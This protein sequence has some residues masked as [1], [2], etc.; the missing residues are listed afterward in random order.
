M[1]RRSSDGGTL[2]PPVPPSSARPALLHPFSGLALLTLQ[3]ASR[4]ARLTILKT[5]MIAA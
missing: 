5:D 2:P 1:I 3:I 4:Q